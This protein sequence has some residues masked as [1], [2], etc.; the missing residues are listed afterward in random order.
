MTEIEDLRKQLESEEALNESLHRYIEALE[1]K[2][3]MLEQKC[4]YTENMVI[5]LTQ[6]LEEL[7]P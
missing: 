7:L 3:K 2:C 5:E 1:G 4:N 6:K